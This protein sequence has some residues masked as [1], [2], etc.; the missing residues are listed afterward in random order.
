VRR[1]TTQALVAVGVSL[2]VSFLA[3]CDSAEMPEPGL[4]PPLRGSSLS[5]AQTV[6]DQTHANGVNVH[7]LHASSNTEEAGWVVCK[8]HPRAGEPAT[9]IRLV[10]A[11]VSTGCP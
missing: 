8:Q 1:T 4:M 3:G 9:N 5:H 2:L 7:Y 11:G 6:L 10:V